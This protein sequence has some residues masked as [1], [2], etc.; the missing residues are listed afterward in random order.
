MFL[1]KIHMGFR[2]FAQKIPSH[3]EAQKAQK[4]FRLTFMPLVFPCGGS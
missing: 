1:K 2:C 4:W 3:K